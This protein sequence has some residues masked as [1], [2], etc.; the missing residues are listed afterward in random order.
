MAVSVLSIQG[1]KG[2]L[3]R[4]GWD[5]FFFH[6]MMDILVLDLTIGIQD[7]NHVPV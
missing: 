4:K 1:L 6:V 5:A 7:K 2:L 3:Y